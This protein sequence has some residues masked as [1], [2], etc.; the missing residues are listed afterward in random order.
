MA[1]RAGC[2]HAGGRPVTAAQRQ[3]TGPTRSIFERVLVGVDGSAESGEA[4]RQAARLCRVQGGLEVVSAV[5]AGNG[6]AGRQ[7]LREQARLEATLIAVGAHGHG[8]PAQ[9][10][11]GGVLS[12]LLLHAPCS[13]LVARPSKGGAAFPRSLAVAVDDSA[14]GERALAEAHELQ[15]RFGVRARV[16]EIPPLGAVESLVSASARVDLLLL[17]CTDPRRAVSLRSL[18]RKLIRNAGSSVLVVR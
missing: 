8:R 10:P 1:A 18:P 11:L 15:E 6:P 16:C 3:V 5:E 17:G 7:L 4:C 13:L 2:R 14:E 12:E 9:I